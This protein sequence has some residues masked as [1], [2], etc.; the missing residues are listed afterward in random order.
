M[1][2]MTFVSFPTS[3][4]FSGLLAAFLGTATGI[5]GPMIY[6]YAEKRDRDR[7]EEIR[8]MNKE[9]FKETGSL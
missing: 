3:V 2:P 4:I 7:L 6:Q 9:K 5:G 1:P 8:Q